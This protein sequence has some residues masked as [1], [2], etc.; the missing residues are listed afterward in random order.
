EAVQV[1]RPGEVAGARHLDGDGPVQLRVAGLV[2]GAEGPLADDVQE[3]ETAQALPVRRGP[4]D[5]GAVLQAEA[6]PA[7][8]AGD[9]VGGADACKLNGVLTLRAEDVHGGTL[10]SEGPV[11]ER[12]RADGDAVP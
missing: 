5:R 8:R 10:R 6:R 7:G 11:S 3:L 1:V 12:W 2:D 9:L 4:A